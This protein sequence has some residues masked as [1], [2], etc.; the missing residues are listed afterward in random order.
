MKS[1]KERGLEAGFKQEDVDSDWFTEFTLV[2]IGDLRRYNVNINNAHELVRGVRSVKELAFIVKQEVE[3]NPYNEDPAWMNPG[4]QVEPFNLG[5]V[6]LSRVLIDQRVAELDKMRASD[7][8]LGEIYE[9]RAK[10][11]NRANNDASAAALD[12]QGAA[13]EQLSPSRGSRR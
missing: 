1:L 8:T 2:A 9:R 6:R 12:L 5:I 13:A 11:Q 10:E 3:K 7:R 4:L